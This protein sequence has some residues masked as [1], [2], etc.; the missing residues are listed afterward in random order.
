MILDAKNFTKS[1]DGT[2]VAEASDLRLRGLPRSFTLENCPEDGMHRSFH[3][4]DADLSGG[5]VAG[6][7][8]EEDSGPNRGR[9]WK[10]GHPPKAV[11]VLKVLIIND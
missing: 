9:S 4:T 8:Y 2:L 10:D 5:D 7:R 3:F 11:P 1:K 6:Y